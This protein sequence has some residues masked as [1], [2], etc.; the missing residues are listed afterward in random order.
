MESIFLG[1]SQTFLGTIATL[2]ILCVFSEKGSGNFIVSVLEGIKERIEKQIEQLKKNTDMDLPQSVQLLRYFLDKSNVESELNNE[3]LKILRDISVKEGELKAQ[4]TLEVEFKKDVLVDQI[5]GAKEQFLAPLYTFLFCLIAFVFDELLHIPSAGK[6][7]LVSGMAL[8]ILYSFL[9]W[10]IVWIN[11]FVTHRI[12][13]KKREKAFIPLRLMEKWNCTSLWFRN[14]GCS[15]GFILRTLV[16]V[17]IMILCIVL[18]HYRFPENS[19]GILI[20]GLSVPVFV[21]GYSRINCFFDKGD[22]SPLFLVGHFAA[23]LVLS[24]FLAF[25]IHLFIYYDISFRHIL[26]PYEN[27]LLMKYSV[28]C[29]AL[30]NGIVFP[31]IFPFVCYNSLYVHAKKT[32]RK[33][34]K[35]QELFFKEFDPQLKEFCGRI[36]SPK[37]VENQ[38]E[39]VNDFE[40]YY[41]EYENEKQK[42]IKIVDFCRKK[43]ID[44]SAFREYRK[45]R[46]RDK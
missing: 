4:Y 26:I 8:F 38:G 41:Q 46:L 10:T 32:A 45:S 22:Y 9:F 40:K 27:F 14:C 44:A 36:L 20:T 30:F 7:W 13:Y 24:F 1:D 34:K 37:S 25:V 43:G 29:F 35:E 11:F 28:L 17:V 39:E 42:G 3:G 2:T 33:T 31:F 12:G 18:A 6:E 19:I 23:I 5:K 15:K 21:K 16:F